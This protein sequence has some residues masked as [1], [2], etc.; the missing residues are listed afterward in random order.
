MKRF[1]IFSFFI[2]GKKIEIGKLEEKE[3]TLSFVEF[4]LSEEDR[5]L[6]ED[7]TPEGFHSLVIEGVTEACM[8]YS[9][10][11]GLIKPY[12]NSYRFGKVFVHRSLF[13]R[14]NIETGIG[15]VK[16]ASRLELKWYC[17]EKD[18]ERT[19]KRFNTVYVKIDM[20]GK[21]R[22]QETRKRK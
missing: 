8:R 9:T 21:K 19:K 14:W 18:V 17:T 12:I 10:I 2:D 4:E 16:N 6:I 5:K 3:R 22:M 11:E 13:E 15:K 7:E 20:K 1:S